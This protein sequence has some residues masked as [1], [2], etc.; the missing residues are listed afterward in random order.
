MSSDNIL[1]LNTIK[2]PLNI[3]VQRLFTY[4]VSFETSSGRGRGTADFMSIP[5]NKRIAIY[6][7]SKGHL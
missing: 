5:I 6:Y 4:L 1:K 3:Y 7:L 2:K